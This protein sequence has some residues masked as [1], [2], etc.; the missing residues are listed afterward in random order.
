MRLV[1]RG[2][3]VCPQGS[4]IRLRLWTEH[5]IQTP[6]PSRQLQCPPSVIFGLS[7]WLNSQTAVA[8]EIL[9]TVRRGDQLS[10]GRYIAVDTLAV[11]RIAVER[12]AVERVAV[13]RIAV[14]PRPTTESA[15]PR[16]RPVPAGV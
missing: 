13:E 10:G 2:A 15:A 12:V 5:S 7:G 6:M 3:S 9:D 1:F 4:R 14:E 16:F 11:E 8:S